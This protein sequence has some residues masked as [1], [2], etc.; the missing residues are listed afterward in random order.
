MEL[1]EQHGAEQ[2]E[3]ERQQ[4]VLKEKLERCRHV[5]AFA[6]G[7]IDELYA[8]QAQQ[9]E[10]SARMSTSAISCHGSGEGDSSHMA[11]EELHNAKALAQEAEAEV[12]DLL[13]NWDEGVRQETLKE[14][15]DT[16][17][18]AAKKIEETVGQ[19]PCSDRTPLRARNTG[20]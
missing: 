10:I 14:N 2:K 11:S 7:S 15:T 13:N 4:D 5:V 18:I 6:V 12:C 1:K 8:Q 3:L 9:E 20:L 16:A 19:G 17:P